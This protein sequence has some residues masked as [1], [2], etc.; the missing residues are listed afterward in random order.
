MGLSENTINKLK[1]Q[2][3]FLK[4]PIIEIKMKHTR[5]QWQK[6]NQSLS[7]EIKDSRKEENPSNFSMELVLQD[8]DWVKNYYIFIVVKKFFLKY[9]KCVLP[10][11]KL[12][13]RTGCHVTQSLKRNACI[14][15]VNTIT[16]KSCLKYA[17][18]KM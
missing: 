18:H 11:A 4:T 15:L 3:H 10:Y 7:Q 1:Y 6:S 12:Y 13:D 9:L 2:K 5:K 17:V 14:W 8:I 16:C